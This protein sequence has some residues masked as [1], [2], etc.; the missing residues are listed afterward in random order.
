MFQLFKSY[1]LKLKKK[2]PSPL[3]KLSKISVK[4]KL[5]ILNLLLQTTTSVIPPPP[6]PVALTC[7]LSTALC[8][9]PKTGPRK[10]VL[11]LWAASLLGPVGA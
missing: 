9:L 10:A 11:L 2:K 6:Q 4:F 7:R 3:F 1:A 8:G 5:R